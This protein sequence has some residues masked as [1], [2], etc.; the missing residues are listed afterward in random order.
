MPTEHGFKTNTARRLNSE[1]LGS[2]SIYLSVDTDTHTIFGIEITDEKTGD[3]KKAIELITQACSKTGSVYALYGVVAYDTKDIFQF[4]SRKGVDPIIR[5]RKNASTRARGCFARADVVR[6]M[7]S[8]AEKRWKK[9]KRYGKRW[10][11]ERGYSMFKHFFG[12][13]VCS[14]RFEYMCT[15]IRQKCAILNYYLKELDEIKW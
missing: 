9:K 10:A 6:N 7:Q 14:R 15:E 2:N 1:N 4:C 3:S 13:D 11:V 8:L 5:V 12:G